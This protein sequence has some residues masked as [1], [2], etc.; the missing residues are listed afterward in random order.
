MEKS[1]IARVFNDLSTIIYLLTLAAIQREEFS[2]GQKTQS[3]SQTMEV[4]F[5]VVSKGKEQQKCFMR[6]L[7]LESET[8]VS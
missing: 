5:Q 6:L 7:P 2:Q 1:F 3:R 4:C 8:K